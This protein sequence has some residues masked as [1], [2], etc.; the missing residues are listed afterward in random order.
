MKHTMPVLL[1]LGWV[2]AAASGALEKGKTNEDKIQGKW[3]AVALFDKDGKRIA[4]NDKFPEGGRPVIWIFAVG[5]G[6]L[7][8][9][10]AQEQRFTFKL[11]PTQKPKTIDLFWIEKGKSGEDAK[12][13]EARPL[14]GIYALE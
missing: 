14:L 4:V 9:G 1:A 6:V 10:T 7:K 11:D 13:D 12:P 2:L 3:T 5:K 8:M